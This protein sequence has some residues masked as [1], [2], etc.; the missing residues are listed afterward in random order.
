MDKPIEPPDMPGRPRAVPTRR[1]P[2]ALAAYRALTR[3]AAPAAPLILG[4][5]ERRG[6]ED[7]ARRG[8]RFGVAS[9]P[10]PAGALAWVHA[11][12]V[13][14]ANA[15]LPVIAQLRAARPDV[16]V[17][18]TT[19]TVTSA[20]FV[21]QRRPD[22]VMH[23]YVPLDA[24][25][26]VARFLDHWRP[27]LVVLTEQEIWPNLVT[28]VHARGIPLTL[29][30]ARMSDRSF[31]RWRRRLPLAVALFS[32]FTAVFAQTRELAERFRTL[33]AAEATAVGNVKI[34]APPLPVDAA[35]H[36]A[37]D[38]ALGRRPRFVAASTHAGEEL[39]IAAAHRELRRHL[40]GFCT[41]IAPRHPER[42][43]GLADAMRMEGLT[44]ARRSLGELPGPST[45]IYIADTIG[46]LGTL[47]ATAPVAFI[48]GSL[49]AHGGQNAVEAVRLGAAVITGP[50]WSNFPDVMGALLASGGA[51]EI[52]TADELAGEVRRLLSD[53]AL[54]ADRRARGEA[55]LA[56]LGGALDRTIAVLLPLLPA[57][58]GHR[59]AARAV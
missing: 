11:A 12:S 8:E 59:G 1:P 43:P 13:G 45:D 3:M 33:G 34:D 36:A 20:R 51:V 10:R 57:S 19:G 44:V 28:T 21:A 39:V 15:V 14:E 40:D 35:A 31:A 48:G 30:N 49:I 2:L 17:L 24:P 55:A 52:R 46:E 54:L 41:I 26:F 56:A 4:Y 29:V 5:R 18:L 23:Q 16:A 47:Y 53:T 27:S 58:I 37:L 7:H 42:G 6:K 38:A 25:G 9:M 50:S 32:C 22:G